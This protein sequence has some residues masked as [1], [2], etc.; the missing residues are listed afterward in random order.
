MK[1]NSKGFFDIKNFLPFI[2]M[3][4]KGTGVG[5]LLNIFSAGALDKDVSNITK[6]LGDSGL[7][8][9]ISNL[10]SKKQVNKTKDLMLTD[11]EIK[12]Y[13]RVE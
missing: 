1:T 11:Y 4:G 8:S 7:F 6:L 13:T 5:D 3:F 12:N 2:N 10:F 9:G